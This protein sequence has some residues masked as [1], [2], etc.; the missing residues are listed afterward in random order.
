MTTFLAI[1]LLAL[2]LWLV[3]HYYQV[4]RRHYLRSKPLTGKQQQLLR[5]LLPLYRHLGT[6]QQRQLQANIALF[7]HDKE[8]VGCDGLQVSERMR[9]AVAAHACLLLLGR[10][11]RCYPNLYTVLLYPDTY[12]A[13]ETHHD[14]YIETTGH[15]A[16]EGEAHYRGPV[17]LSWADL[18]EDLAHPGNGRN[19]ALHEFAHKLDEEDGYYDGRPLFDQAGEGKNWASVLSAEYE[20]LRQRAESGELAED[21]PSALDLYGAESPAEFF[22]VATES[23]FVIPSAVRDAH[24]QLYRELCN[25]YRLDPAATLSGDPPTGRYP[26]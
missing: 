10:E 25:F 6:E 4:W 1:I 18:E 24:P 5:E 13:I 14:G 8:F 20:R 11:N 22:A 9:V 15:S 17:V 21:M 16:R 7:L 2:L 19:V 23:F 3:P 26:E 12:V